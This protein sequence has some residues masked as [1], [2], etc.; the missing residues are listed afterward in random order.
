MFFNPGK[1]QYELQLGSKGVM[2]LGWSTVSTKFSQEKGV[3]KFIF[4]S[5]CSVL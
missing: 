4:V 5:V 3:G 1:W 2:Q